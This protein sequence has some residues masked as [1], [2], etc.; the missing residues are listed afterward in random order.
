MRQWQLVLLCVFSLF[1]CLVAPQPYVAIS[2]YAADSTACNGT[3]VD[4]SVYPDLTCLFA[5]TH[6]TG[7][8]CDGENVIVSNCSDASCLSCSIVSNS[9]SCVSNQG[10]KC[11]SSFPATPGYLTTASYGFTSPECTTLPSIGTV[12]VNPPQ[13]CLSISTTYSLVLSCDTL[14]NVIIQ[15]NCSAYKCASCTPAS[16]VFNLGCVDSATAGYSSYSC[17]NSLPSFT[18]GAR[19]T[20]TTSTPSTTTPPPTSGAVSV[21]DCG[22]ITLLACFFLLL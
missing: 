9:S 6:Y 11:Y 13:A 10:Y 5:T 19:T 12:Y 4:V 1:V 17:S 8:Q 16:E 20:T 2:N 21:M 14:G 7:Y 22:V 18:T 3:L 15:Q